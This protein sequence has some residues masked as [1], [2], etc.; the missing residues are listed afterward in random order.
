MIKTKQHVRPQESDAPLV[1]PPRSFRQSSPQERGDLAAKLA[2]VHRCFDESG[3]VEISLPH[4]KAHSIERNSAGQIL[5]MSWEQDTLPP[6][7]RDA[8]VNLGAW[9]PYRQFRREVEIDFY[10]LGARSEI[11]SLLERGE[12]SLIAGPADRFPGSAGNLKL[13]VSTCRLPEAENEAII[14]QIQG[15][16]S[17]RDRRSYVASDEWARSVIRAMLKVV[18]YLGYSSFRFENDLP[19]WFPRP[20]P[21][22]VIRK[23]FL[24]G[25][26]VKHAAQAGFS[27]F[28]MEHGGVLKFKKPT[29]VPTMVHHARIEALESY[30]DGFCR[31]LCSRAL[32][33]RP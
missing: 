17:P 22:S 11:P 32:L 5:F 1:L 21:L 13:T 29:A 14:R 4:L 7:R 24:E 28:Q 23:E 19:G 18:E 15:S 33:N 3:Q 9:D 8:C 16:S 25:C 20:V 12:R 10:V 6:E 27:L 2:S 31:A 26:L 30:P